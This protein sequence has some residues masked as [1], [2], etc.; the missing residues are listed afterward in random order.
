MV[1]LHRYDNKTPLKE[2]LVAMKEMLDSGKVHYWGTSEWPAVRIMQ[3]MHMCDELKMA[4]PIA[5][6]CEYNMLVRQKM[7]VD[8]AALFDDYGLATTIWSPMKSG[9][10]TGIYNAG[11]PENSRLAYDETTKG[12]YNQ[13]FGKNVRDQTLKMLNDLSAIAK[14][15]KMTMGQLALAWALEYKNTTSC[16][17]RADNLEQLEENFKCLTLKD[18]LTPKIF[19][20][21][22][23]TLNN[24]PM[25]D[26]DYKIF[27]PIPNRR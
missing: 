20:K 7:E 18:K 24:T 19:K 10:L 21:I 16:V 14:G 12:F 1:F 5:E 15:Q 2:T 25:P 23:D 11:I 9:V 27:Q 3:A 13:Y 22:N 4:R 17:I 8:Y 6:Q 26:I